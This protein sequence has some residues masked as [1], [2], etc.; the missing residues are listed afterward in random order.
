MLSLLE[1][2]SKRVNTTSEIVIETENINL[3]VVNHT[4]PDTSYSYQ[5]KLEQNSVK[6]E[7]NISFIHVRET[8]MVISVVYGNGFI[9]Y[10]YGSALYK[11]CSTL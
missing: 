8:N 6:Q 2:Y 10:K 5:P 1:E 7:V 3:Q 9:W 4:L 11:Y